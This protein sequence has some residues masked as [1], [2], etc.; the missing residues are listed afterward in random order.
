MVVI[1]AQHVTDKDKKTHISQLSGHTWMPPKSMPLALVLFVKSC[2]V[3]V[4]HLHIETTS[5]VKKRAAG[6]E[7]PAT[8]FWKPKTASGVRKCAAAVACH[9]TS[10][11]PRMEPYRCLP[12][13]R[14]SMQSS[15]SHREAGIWGLSS[16]RGFSAPQKPSPPEVTRWLGSSS[17][18][19][20]AISPIH[21]GRLSTHSGTCWKFHLS[22]ISDGVQVY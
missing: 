13:T 12:A 4:A 20:P 14:N 1:P 9:H 18:M 5:E 3:C 7:L 10:I 2:P 19:Y 11:T 21:A 8:T 16:A 15:R 17:F 22:V 6:E